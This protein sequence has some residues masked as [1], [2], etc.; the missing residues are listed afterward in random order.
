MRDGVSK[1]YNQ[2]DKVWFLGLVPLVVTIQSCHAAILLLWD[3]SFYPPPVLGLLSA[4]L[5]RIP[6]V[7]GQIQLHLL[8]IYGL[9]DGLVGLEFVD[10]RLGAV[11]V[12]LIWCCYTFVIINS[13]DLYFPLR[14]FVHKSLHI[15]RNHPLSQLLNNPIST[16][17]NN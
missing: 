2:S 5:L 11:F 10:L 9:V 7:F 3:L 14:K 8:E 15:Q 1:K 13:E 16:F 4:H 17:D 12:T 6:C